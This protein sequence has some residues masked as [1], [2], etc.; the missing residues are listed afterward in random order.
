MVN[1]LSVHVGDLLVVRDDILHVD[2][3][4]STMAE[5]CGQIVTVREIFND[6]NSTAIS[7]EEDSGAFYWFSECFDIYEEPGEL[8]SLNVE[9]L[10][11]EVV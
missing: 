11:D 4:V 2:G 3:V 10:F 9:M 7:I 8:Q 6:A 5:Y 1:L